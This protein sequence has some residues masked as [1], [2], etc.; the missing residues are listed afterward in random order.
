MKE[1]TSIILFIFLSGGLDS[2]GIAVELKR[3]NSDYI[4]YTTRKFHHFDMDRK[5]A[6]FVAD[7]LNV[8][9]E[10]YDLGEDVFRKKPILPNITITFMKIKYGICQRPRESFYSHSAS[11]LNNE[12]IPKKQERINYAFKT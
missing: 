11:W 6:A 3:Q 12:R 7:T 8:K 4:S 1:T 2:S 5:A 10:F 9:N